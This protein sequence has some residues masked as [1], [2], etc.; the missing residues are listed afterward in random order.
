MQ[1]LP[2]VPYLFAIAGFVVAFLGTAQASSYSFSTAGDF[3]RVCD[4]SSPPEECLNAVMHVEQIVNYGDH[5][6]DT[7]DGGPQELLKAT[8]NEEL[9]A[10]L[11][12]RVINIVPWLKAHSEYSNQSYGDGIWAALKGVYC[13]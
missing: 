5:P 12:E 7:C 6:N 9:D 10:S 3:V 1:R 11:R 4:G 2:L 13:R 8:T